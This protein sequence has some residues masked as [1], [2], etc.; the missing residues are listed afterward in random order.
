MR[1]H[2]A[3]ILHRKEELFKLPKSSVFCSYTLSPSNSMVDH[4]LGDNHNPVSAM[5]FPVPYLSNAESENN[6]TSLLQIK[7][8]NSHAL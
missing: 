3:E 6:Y 2:E 8:H 4:V 5:G 7:Y 1:A